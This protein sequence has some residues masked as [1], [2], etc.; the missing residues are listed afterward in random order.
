MLIYSE[1]IKKNWKIE[2]RSF[3]YPVIYVVVIL[4]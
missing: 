2:R 1:M 4:L 3:F